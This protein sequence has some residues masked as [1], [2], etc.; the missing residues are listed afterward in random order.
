[1][2]PKFRSKKEII[3]DTLCA[4]IVRG[5]YEPG[6][7]LVIDDIAKQ[8]GVSPIPI[9]EAIQ[10]LEADGFVTF[11]PYVGAATTEMDATF[12]FEVFALLES[13]EVIS[14]RIA[15]AHMDEAA[16]ATLSQMLAAMDAL[17][18]APEQ[19]SE[20]NKAFHLTICDIAGTQLVAKMM[21]KT[22]A[23]W[24]RLRNHYLQGITHTRI[25]E[26][27]A[28]HHKLLAAFRAGDVDQVE[29]VIRDHNQTALAYYIQHLKEKGHLTI[30]S[31]GT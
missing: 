1:M 22:F 4:D 2:A 8:M 10:Q 27:Q 11:E 31:D 5:H 30:E 12:L 23:H 13:V 14:S 19:W 15:T 20:Q 9:R 18:D 7:R 26:A 16:L 6:T 25:A 17:V 24:D 28:Q 21:R 29:Q 3:Y